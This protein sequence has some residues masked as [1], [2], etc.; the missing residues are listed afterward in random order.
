VD[1]IRRHVRT[2]GLEQEAL[3]GR[4]FDDLGGVCVGGVGDDA[5]D[6]DEGVGK[7]GEDGGG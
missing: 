4:V 1:I 5:G 7:V 2:V 6:A 3:E